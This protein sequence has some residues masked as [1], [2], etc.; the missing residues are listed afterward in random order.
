MPTDG[1]AFTV[2]VGREDQFVV[3]FKRIN[4]RFNMLFTVRS[5]FPFHVK[6]FIWQ[7]RAI[8]GRQVTDVSVRRQNSIVAAQIFVYCLGL[9]RRFDDDDWHMKLS[10]SGGVEREL[11]NVVDRKGMSMRANVKGEY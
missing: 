5:D 7:D 10:K 8:L 11:L 3:V 1:L 2:R 4:N 9:S 6:I